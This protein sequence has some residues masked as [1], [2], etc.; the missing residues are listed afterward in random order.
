MVVLMGRLVAVTAAV[1]MEMAGWEVAVEGS[2]AMVAVL[3]LSAGVEERLREETM[4]VAQVDH[5][6]DAEA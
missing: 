1:H 4:A 5:M 3:E 2:L 6:E